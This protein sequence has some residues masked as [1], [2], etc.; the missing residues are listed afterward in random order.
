MSILFCQMINII[1]H[2][3]D[4]CQMNDEQHQTMSD[5][6]MTKEVSR[7]G[8][9]SGVCGGSLILLFHENRKTNTP[10]FRFSSFS[11]ASA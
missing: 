3:R 11:S 4:S 10:D 2:V 9:L 6:Y 5:I 1:H 7:K 8:D